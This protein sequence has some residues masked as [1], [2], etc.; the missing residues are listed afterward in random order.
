LQPHLL[1]RAFS[2]RQSALGRYFFAPTPEWDGATMVG[3]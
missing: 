3:D 1:E 2:V